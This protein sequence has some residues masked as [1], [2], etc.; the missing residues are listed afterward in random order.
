[1]NEKHM[2]KNVNN[3]IKTLNNSNEYY[4]VTYNGEGIY[5]ALKNIVGYY[6]WKSLLNNKQINWLP[7]PPEY[8]SK[9]IAQKICFNIIINKEY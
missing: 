9:N 6:T 2:N 4:R 8:S 7:K 3:M 5:N 1:M